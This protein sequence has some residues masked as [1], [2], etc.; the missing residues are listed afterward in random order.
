MSNCE[1]CGTEGHIGPPL[2]AGEFEIA[3]GSVNSYIDRSMDDIDDSPMLFGHGNK[4]Y[5]YPCHC[6]VT[7]RCFQCDTDVDYLFRDKRCK[8]LSY[9]CE[10]CLKR[11]STNHIWKCY[12][13]GCMTI[14]EL[15][16]EEFEMMNE[17]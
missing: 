5:C 8:N 2:L 13:N 17:N 3:L 15:A 12:K 11:N 14:E 10:T 6:L 4:H 16:Q 9:V 7:N 1:Q